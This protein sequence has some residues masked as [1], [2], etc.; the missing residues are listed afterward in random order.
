MFVIS[1][2]NF[3]V[4]RADGTSYLVKKDFVGDIPKDIFESSVIQ[5]AIKGGLVATPDSTKDQALYAAD[6]AA[7]EKE[8]DADIRP[9]IARR[10]KQ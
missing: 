7:A 9:D 8:K 5:G 2:R 3:L 1:K 4:R 6:A 10:K